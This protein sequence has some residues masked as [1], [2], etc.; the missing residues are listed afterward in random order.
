M[1]PQLQVHDP[2]PIVQGMGNGHDCTL[3]NVVRL[4]MQHLLLLQMALCLQV[5]LDEHQTA[6]FAATVMLTI[7]N[8]CD[9]AI[10]EMPVVKSNKLDEFK[11]YDSCRQ[12]IPSV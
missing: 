11:L 6:C 2:A 9:N 10:A 1:H 12:H 3:A 4:P 7:H 5:G 8:I